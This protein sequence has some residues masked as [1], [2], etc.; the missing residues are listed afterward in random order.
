M[1][2]Q[3]QNVNVTS[4]D[5]SNINTSSGLASLYRM[6]GIVSISE[7]LSQQ[8]YP[9][10]L[11]NTLEQMSL[12]TGAFPTGVTL[13]NNGPDATRNAT[14]VSVYIDSNS[15]G[16]GSNSNIL[17]APT[18]ASLLTSGSSFTSVYQPYVFDGSALP[19][20][21]T[22]VTIPNPSNIWLYV[23]SGLSVTG[24]F[25]IVLYYSL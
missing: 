17:L 21:L 16:S 25:N 8:V 10:L 4:Q 15:S 9:I 19:P 20:T 6:Y 14:T 11:T 3:V 2:L 23:S 7:S 18:R 24:T 5:I 12:P 22:A 13:S 1:S